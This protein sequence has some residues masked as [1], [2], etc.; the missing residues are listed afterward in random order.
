MIAD[1]KFHFNFFNAGNSLHP[2]LA[3]LLTVGQDDRA[4]VKLSGKVKPADG[5]PEY[6]ATVTLKVILIGAEDGS[7]NCWLIDGYIEGGKY[8]KG[9]I[10]LTDGSG[11]LVC[12]R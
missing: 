1:L 12:E 3:S 5:K 8:V 9:F 6:D 10:R 2:F 11:H 4:A 7:G